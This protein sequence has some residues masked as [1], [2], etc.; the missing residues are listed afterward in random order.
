[1]LTSG[2]FT[3]EDSIMSRAI[4]VALAVALI[5]ATGP[6]QAAGRAMPNEN[7]ILSVERE[8]PNYVQ[9]VDVRSLSPDQIAALHLAL[10]RSASHSEIRGE[11]RSIIGG[12]DVL[13]TG[14]NLFFGFN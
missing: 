5:T 7:L 14:R 9:G 11:V 6:A 8:L 13:L 1:M 2:M 10:Y 4:I 12:M 3:F